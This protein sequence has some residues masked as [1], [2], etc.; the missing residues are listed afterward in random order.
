MYFTKILTATNLITLDFQSWYMIAAAETAWATAC[1][2]VVAPLC[3]KVSKCSLVNWQLALH[4]NSSPIKK[5]TPALHTP[6]TII[7]FGLHYTP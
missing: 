4:P 1:S 2:R 5:S 6:T 3:H 7:Y